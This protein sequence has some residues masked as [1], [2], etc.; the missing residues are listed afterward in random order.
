MGTGLDGH[1]DVDAQ[2]IIPRSIHALFAHLPLTYPL[3]NTYQVSVSFLELYNEELIDLLNPTRSSTHWQNSE[4][5]RPGSASSTKSEPNNVRIREDEFGNIVWVG[6]REEICHTPEQLLGILSKGSLCRTTGSTDM[7][8]VSSRS[9]AIFS[10]TLRISKLEPNGSDFQKIQCKFHFV[11]LAGSERLKKTNAEGTRAKEGISINSGLLALGNVISALGDESRQEQRSHIPYRDSKLTRLLQDSLGGNSQTLMLACVSP[12]DSN[13]QETLNTLKY[14][15]RARN[16]KNKVVINQQ[17]SMNTLEVQQLRTQINRLKLELSALKEVSGV[18]LTRS[19][20]FDVLDRSKVTDLQKENGKLEFQVH[21]LE[22]RTQELEHQVVQLQADRDSLLLQVHGLP[23]LPDPSSMSSHEPHPLIQEYLTKISDLKRQL[24]NQDTELNFLKR[25]LSMLSQ[26]S[27]YWEPSKRPY[28]ARESRGF[29]VPTMTSANPTSSLTGGSIPN[30]ADASSFSSIHPLL[31]K[32]KEQIQQDVQFLLSTSSFPSFDHPV[33]TSFEVGGGK[34]GENGH[35]M[36]DPN[37]LTSLN[38]KHL[39][40][41]TTPTMSTSME[42][43]TNTSSSSAATTALPH[44]STT[45]ATPTLFLLHKTLQRVQSNLA[46]QEELVQALEL[47]HQNYTTMQHS[48]EEKFSQLQVNVNSIK[49]ER[50]QALSRIQGAHTKEKEKELR[51]KFETKVK[52][53]LNEISQ[54]RRTQLDTSKVM[55]SSKKSDYV[56]KQ[57]RAS[58]EA[59]KLEKQRL[60]KKVKDDAEK[61]KEQALL[62]EREIQKLKKKEK[63]ALDMVKKFERNFELQKLLL[64]KRTE[65]VVTSHQK[66]KNLTSLLH[67]SSSSQKSN[68]LSSKTTSLDPMEPTHMDIVVSLKDRQQTLYKAIETI[69]NAQR[70]HQQMEDLIARRKQLT[71]EKLVLQKE[72][73]HVLS[74]ATHVEPDTTLYLDEPIALM[75]AELYYL[76]TRIKSLQNDALDQEP[77]EHSYEYVYQSLRSLNLDDTMTLLQSFID[78]VI[79][80]QI[81]TQN[82]TMEVKQL[83]E[84]T[85]QLR[86]TVFRMRNTAMGNT[87]H[88]EKKIKTL[89]SS[90]PPHLFYSSSPVPPPSSSS[91]IVANATVVSRGNDAPR[92]DV[93]PTSSSSSSCSLPPSMTS[94]LEEGLAPSGL[95]T[96][97]PTPT[98]TTTTS[99]LESSKSSPPIVPRPDSKSTFPSQPRRRGTVV[100]GQ[101][102]FERL[103]KTYT[104]ASQAKVR[105]PHR[106]DTT[107]GNNPP[108]LGSSFLPPPPPPPPRNGV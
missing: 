27:H 65:E 28:S 31:L 4:V 94:S 33:E 11:D 77:P 1:F 99:T 103:A 10:V 60:L 35:G 12:A 51:S 108:P 15:N 88:Y 64:K 62:H 67:R 72:R 23:P 54:L 68:K 102:V 106:D 32:A 105:D 3:P 45:T 40:T 107:D 38:N 66:L 82:Q 26:V 76:E 52:Q 53:L 101:D 30:M 47:T 87:F 93:P 8:M 86:R 21:R 74:H 80:L 75:D 57:L 18:P 36:T 69:V 24:H 96:T 84:V 83:H 92:L 20:S 70:F 79:Q 71:E 89:P 44:T 91:P 6:V 29:R 39:S 49:Q 5:L 104:V 2:G 41:L 34:K 16:I 48:Y 22:E 73:E 100:S 59:L 58:L 37:P 81:V 17:G 9:H 63:L 78:D 55:T 42:G 7:N 98:T 14:A 13:F 97:T 19:N 95:M 50:D 43:A 46:L 85:A 90:S 56:L 61:A 25:H